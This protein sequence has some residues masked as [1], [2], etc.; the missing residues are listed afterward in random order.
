[1]EYAKREK[2]HLTLLMVDVDYFKKFNDFYGHLEGDSALIAVANSLAQ[3][4]RRSLD[5]AGRYGGE[6]FILVWFD[7]KPDESEGL[8]NLVQEKIAALKIDH[9]Q[10]KVGRYL[11]LSGGLITIIPSESTDVQTLINKAD[12]LLYQSKDLGRNRISIYRS[13]SDPQPQ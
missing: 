5:F 3:C 11:T 9:Q 4:C 10:S 8:S 6:E 12:E 13:P 2:R 7:T 1:M